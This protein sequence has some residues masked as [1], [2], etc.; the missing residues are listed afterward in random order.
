VSN[1][2][3]ILGVKRA[4]SRAGFWPWPTSPANDFDQ[5]YNQNFASKGVA[6]FQKSVGIDATGN[7][8]E[9]TH[10]ALST[11]RCKAKP[12][13]WAFDI[14]SINMIEYA[15]K[16]LNQKP[17]DIVKQRVRTMLSFARLFDGPYVFGGEHDGTFQDD[18]I[19][20]GFDCSSSC[21][22]LLWKFSLLGTNMAQVSGWFEKWGVGGRGK[23]ITI[24]AA[25]D[26]VW[27]EFNIDGQYYRFDTSPH[28][29]GVHGPRVRTVRRSDSRF[30]HRHPSGF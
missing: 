9:P 28:G 12:T 23:Y 17:D 29:D 18:D 21:S 11:T 10:E 8:G 25:D 2:V 20:D 1:G 14:T 3:D 16:E 24:H 6:A 26:H 30:V 15:D 22:F 7:Y 19:H 27:M 5:A 4:I 13:E